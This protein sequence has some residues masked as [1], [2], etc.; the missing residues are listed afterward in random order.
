MARDRELLRY[1]CDLLIAAPA[2]EVWA[3]ISDLSGTPGWAGSG[4]SR[5]ITKVTDGPIGV[6][7]RYRSSE[8]ITMPYHADS[9]ITVYE[10]DAAIEWISKPVGERVPYH[11]WSFR[12]EPA[13]DGTRL[14]HTVRAARATGFMGW[15]QRLAFLFTRPRQT[16]PPGMDETV[17]RIKALVEQ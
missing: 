5:S 6:G 9:E 4:H 15:V 16:I 2:S 17:G 8:K 14:R 1:E 10:P 11:H 12:L 7:T 13:P 3:V